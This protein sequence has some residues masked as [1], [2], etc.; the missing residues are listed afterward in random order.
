MILS[1][2]FLFVLNNV[3]LSN[4]NTVKESKLNLSTLIS[5]IFLECFNDVVKLSLTYVFN[6][7]PFYQTFHLVRNLKIWSHLFCTINQTI[8]NMYRITKK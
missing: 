8:D 6:L 7:T 1:I 2:V 3:E 5:I 4:E